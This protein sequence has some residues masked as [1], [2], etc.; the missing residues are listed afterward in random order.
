VKVSS[1]LLDGLRDRGFEVTD[2]EFAIGRPDRLTVTL[3][4]GSGPMVIAKQVPQGGA[5]KLFCNMRAVWNSSF[6]AARKPPGLPKPID[7][8][9]ELDIVIME[10]VEGKT[11]AEIGA[12]ERYF[13]PAIELMAALHSSDAAGETERGARS[14]VRSVKRKAEA[15]SSRLPEH[16]K[17]VQ[18]AVAAMEANRPKDGLL[19]PSHGDCSP[20]NVLMSEGERLVL[21]DWERFQMADPARDLAYFATWGWPEQLKRGRLPDD[22]LLKHAVKIYERDRPGISL[23]KQVRFYA[24]AGLIRR[25][26]SL[27]ELWPEQS[28]LV[29]A[30]AKT[31][32]RQFE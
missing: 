15:I 31:A 32:L 26:A 16:T 19:V 22:S 11:L 20:R 28:Y 4:H 3:A 12:P 29:P 17:V 7:W 9:P 23:R 21:I 24:A 1:D 25:A 18:E 8:I 30:L 13:E 6:G 14:V 27:A 10:R 5:E 2:E